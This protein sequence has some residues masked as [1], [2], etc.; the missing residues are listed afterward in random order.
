MTAKKVNA[1]PIDN[2]TTA[3]A[4][5]ATQP[6]NSLTEE[7]IKLRKPLVL[8]RNEFLQKLIQT[9]NDSGLPFVIM[10]Y[11]VRDFYDEVR[12]SATQQYEKENEE[13]NNLLNQYA[14]SNDAK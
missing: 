4:D 3:H 6:Q 11:V 2:N 12:K 8:A 1:E 7:D 9:A 10:E 5:T 13:Y 14:E